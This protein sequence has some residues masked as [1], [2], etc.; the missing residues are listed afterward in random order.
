M[1][2][3]IDT[4]ALIPLLVE[5]DT[6]HEG[7]RKA[8]HRLLKDGRELLTTSYVVIETC[9]VLQSRIGLAPVELLHEAILPV[10]SIEWVEARLHQ[11]GF[12]RFVR[13]GRGLLSLVDCVSFEAMQARGL[14]DALALDA[15]F[16]D[17]GFR[18][19][20]E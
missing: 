16:R 4:S 17:A 10:V 13:E 18:T 7:V 20:P 9:A 2:A 1:S 6:D 11:R 5:N 8:F 19:L 3:F 14:R 12:D 15:D